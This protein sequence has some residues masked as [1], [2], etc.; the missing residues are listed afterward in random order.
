MLSQHGL[1]PV[2]FQESCL[3]EALMPDFSWVW[4]TPQPWTGS[5]EAPCWRVALGRHALSACSSQGIC[6]GKG[7]LLEA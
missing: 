2:T 1:I 6:E 5:W 3:W 4:G 7:A